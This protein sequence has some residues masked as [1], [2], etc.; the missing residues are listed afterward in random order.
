M[1]QD[2]PP[3]SMDVGILGADA[4][5]QSANTG[6]HLV[7]QLR[8]GRHFWGVFSLAFRV[9]GGAWRG[10]RPLR[11]LDPGNIGRPRGAIQDAFWGVY[12]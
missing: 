5:I 4:V 9:C 11:S 1:K 6:A 2:K 7:K 12:L 10:Y 3:H 8:L